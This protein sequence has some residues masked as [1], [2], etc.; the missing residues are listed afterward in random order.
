MPLPL[1]K[2]CRKVLCKF[3]CLFIFRRYPLLHSQPQDHLHNYH[4]LRGASDEKLIVSSA[5][6]STR[7][8]A[9]AALRRD[10]AEARWR[11]QNRLLPDGGRL[12]WHLAPRL[13]RDL[14]AVGLEPGARRYGQALGQAPAR[15]TRTRPHTK[16]VWS[17]QGLSP[18]TATLIGLNL[19]FLAQLTHN[20]AI[21]KLL[22][23]FSV[24]WSLLG[25]QCSVWQQR[26]S[27]LKKNSNR[28]L[29][30]FFGKHKYKCMLVEFFW[31][32]Q[33]WIYLDFI[34]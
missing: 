33:I 34:F 1:Y 3:V 24:F 21:V 19:S 4:H 8:A 12:A 29:L 20:Q 13:Y 25:L 30:T 14:A 18:H 5:V 10:W 32:I 6:L 27:G 31:Q 16:Q 23:A 7:V 28:F 22:L 2:T 11:R 17:Y 15:P 26:F 9:A